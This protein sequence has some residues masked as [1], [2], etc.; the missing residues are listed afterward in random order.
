MADLLRVKNAEKLSTLRKQDHLYKWKHPICIYSLDTS[1]Q[2]MDCYLDSENLRSK[3][4][5]HHRVAPTQCPVS[6][7]YH[8]TRQ[9]NK[10]CGLCFHMVTKSHKESL[11]N[12]VKGPGFLKEAGMRKLNFTWGEQFLRAKFLGSLVDHR[13]QNLNLDS[14]SIV[15]NGSLIRERL[16]QEHSQ[17]IDI[18]AVLCDSFNERTSI[19]IGRGFGDQF[20]KLYEVARWC[21]MFGIKFR[22]DKNCMPSQHGRRH[23]LT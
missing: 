7:S 16:L 6:V 3:N 13:K 11:V 17:N 19:D 20:A 8:F 10:S 14:V 21:C 15:T 2:K 9:C 5:I 12:A 23:E 4:E 22:I 18:I 1:F